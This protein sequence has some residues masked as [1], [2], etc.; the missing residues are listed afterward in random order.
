MTVDDLLEKCL[1]SFYVEMTNEEFEAA[2]RKQ[3]KGDWLGMDRKHTDNVIE[4]ILT[5]KI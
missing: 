3:P 4:L 5:G 2:G 1:L